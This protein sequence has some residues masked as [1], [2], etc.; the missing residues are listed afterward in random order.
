[1]GPCKVLAQWLAHSKNTMNVSCCCYIA[2]SCSAATTVGLLRSFSMLMSALSLQQG[3]EQFSLSKTDLTTN[4]FFHRTSGWIHVFLAY[5]LE[6]IVTDISPRD[7]GSYSL[8]I[9]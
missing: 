3:P 7:P 1:M 2:I 6:N 9:D 8:T 5:C 4:S